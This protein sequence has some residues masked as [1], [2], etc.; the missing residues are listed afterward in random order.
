MASSWFG[1]LYD[2]L[3]NSRGL[4]VWDPVS[5]MD[6]IRKCQ[7]GGRWRP[8]EIEGIDY[9]PYENVL[10]WESKFRQE[11]EALPGS[12]TITLQG[13]LLKEA[14]SWDLPETW[15]NKADFVRACKACRRDTFAINQRKRNLNRVINRIQNELRTAANYKTVEAFVAQNRMEVNADTN[16]LLRF[17]ARGGRPLWE[18]G[19]VE[20]KYH[21]AT[22]ST[23]LYRSSEFREDSYGNTAL[24]VGERR[25][26]RKVIHYEEMFPPPRKGLFRRIWDALFGA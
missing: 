15:E 22:S 14:R 24:S 1:D 5:Y 3:D 18:T 17:V 13:E 16:D 12:G 25:D 2:S 6:L 8:I 7:Q 10:P 23:T 20:V 11:Y 9:L 26:Y 19:G 21:M 4:S